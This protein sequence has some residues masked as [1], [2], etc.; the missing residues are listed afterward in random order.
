MTCAIDLVVKLGGSLQSQ[1]DLRDICVRLDRSLQGS[2]SM[3]VPGGGLL[4]DGVRNLDVLH[5]LQPGTSH[6]MAVL[7]LD[8]NGLML[9]DL[10]PRGIPVTSIREAELACGRGDLPILLPADLLMAE[11]P[12]PGNW[13][14]TSDSISCWAAVRFGAG[15]LLILKDSLPEGSMTA[16][17]F[18]KRGWLDRFFPDQFRV[19]EGK[20]WIGNGRFPEEALSGKGIIEILR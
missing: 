4:A 11:D 13:D 12:L 19:F 6:W 10:V 7:A 9:G 15:R 16:E 2:P 14:V 5:S 18:S 17:G 1:V 3:I 8:Q 20:A